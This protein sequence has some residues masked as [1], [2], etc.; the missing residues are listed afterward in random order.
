MTVASVG[1]VDDYQTMCLMQCFWES[2]HAGTMDKAQALRHAIRTARQG[3]S[4]DSDAACEACG[5][6]Q[7]E[8]CSC[9]GLYGM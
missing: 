4:S 6:F 3:A 1:K 2:V 8:N 5:L 9:T 7:L